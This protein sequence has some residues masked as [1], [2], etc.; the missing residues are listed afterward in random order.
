MHI[1]SSCNILGKKRT[2]R[3]Y[4]DFLQHTSTNNVNFGPYF[5]F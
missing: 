5:Y 1:R 4:D 3:S 2:V